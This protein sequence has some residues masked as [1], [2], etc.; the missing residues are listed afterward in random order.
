MKNTNKHQNNHRSRSGW[1]KSTTDL[2]L[3]E[4]LPSQIEGL[5]ENKNENGKK[6]RITH[7][8]EREDAPLCN[9]KKLGTM[10]HFN[11]DSQRRFPLGTIIKKNQMAIPRELSSQ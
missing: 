8:R 7:T 5:K 11:G 6:I 3:D 4:H 9:T 2:D 10:T 1:N